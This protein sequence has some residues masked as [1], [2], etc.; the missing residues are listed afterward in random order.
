MAV[1]DINAL[2]A[3]ALLA[4]RQGQRAT[5]ARFWAEILA[6]DPRHYRAL[7]AHGQHEA[8]R[9]DLESARLAFLRAAE[10]NQ[11]DPTPWIQVAQIHRTRREDFDMLLA[12]LLE[13][14]AVLS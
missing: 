2:E 12:T 10:L 11:P 4:E 5:A 3:Q 8:L 14:G 9:G 6:A 7:M 13:I 1:P